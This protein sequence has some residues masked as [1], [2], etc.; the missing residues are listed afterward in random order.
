[1]VVSIDHTRR[2]ENYDE[3]EEGQEIVIAYQRTWT[4][5]TDRCHGTIKGILGP[6]HDQSY[7]IEPTDGDISAITLCSK[8]NSVGTIDGNSVHDIAIL[9]PTR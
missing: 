5:K 4:S 3:L 9:E 1:M 6:N 7:V 8:A 2:I